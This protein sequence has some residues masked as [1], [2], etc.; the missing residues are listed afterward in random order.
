MEAA[1]R[2]AG[3]IKPADPGPV[4]IAQVTPP[5][6]QALLER[7][8]IGQPSPPLL[9]ENGVTLVMIC[10][11]STQAAGLPSRE[12]IAEE[13]FNSRVGL[14]AQQTLDELHR[15]GDIQVLED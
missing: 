10:G 13:L 12:Q 4:N 9:A 3:S 8:P 15:Q 1:N 7:L 11:R 6:F 14:A 2:A 5:Q